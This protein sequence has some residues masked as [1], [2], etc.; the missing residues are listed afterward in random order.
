MTASTAAHRQ[1]AALV[2]AA[3]DHQLDGHLNRPAGE[4]PPAPPRPVDP[5][6][7]PLTL[8]LRRAHNA[9]SRGSRMPWA[10]EGEREYQR[11]K[12][13]AQRDRERAA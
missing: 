6:L 8:H 5:S 7:P 11:L 9:Y 12:K 10:V 2:Q 4:I 13:R 1:A 3:A